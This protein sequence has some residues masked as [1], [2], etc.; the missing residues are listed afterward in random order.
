VLRL[1]G[2]VIRGLDPRI[3]GESTSATAY[4][5]VQAA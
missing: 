4:P 2:T 1:L 5:N 3:H